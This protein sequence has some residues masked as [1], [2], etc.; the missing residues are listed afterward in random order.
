MSQLA[1]IVNLPGLV[2]YWPCDEATGTTVTDVT[3]SPANGAVSGSGGVLGAWNSPGGIGAVGL[4]PATSTLAST[5]GL[6]VNHTSSTPKLDVGDNFSVGM[7]F[8][9]RAAVT[10]SLWALGP[11][12]SAV[13]SELLIDSDFE[14]ATLTSWYVP[15]GTVTLDST[16]SYSG[17]KSAKIAVDASASN[18]ALYQTLYGGGA[19]DQ[20]EYTVTFWYKNDSNTTG[21]LTFRVAYTDGLGASQTITSVL[22]PYSATWTQ[23]TLTFDLTEPANDLTIAFGRLITAGGGVAYNMWV[24]AVSVKCAPVNPTSL[25]LSLDDSG[26]VNFTIGVTTV[27]SSSSPINDYLNWHY[28]VL[29]K[30]GSTTNLYIDGADVTVA[31]TNATFSTAGYHH[32]W[33]SGGIGLQPVVAGHM[34]LV[35]RAITASEQKM[36]FNSANM[37]PDK[38]TPRTLKNLRMGFGGFSTSYFAVPSYY[39]PPETISSAVRAAHATRMREMFTWDDAEPTQGT[40]DWSRNDG[41]VAAHIAN[42]VNIWAGFIISSPSWANS[43]SNKHV[44]PGSAYKGITVAAANNNATNGGKGANAYTIW[45]DLYIN[46]IVACV[47]RYKDRVFQWE[48]GNENNMSGASG[49]GASAP[50]FADFYNAARSAILAELGGA[51]YEHTV[52]LGPM[53][54][55]F[56]ETG[57]FLTPPGTNDTYSYVG[58]EFIRAL[59]DNGLGEIDRIGINPYLSNNADPT[60]YAVNGR[61]LS[62]VHQLRDTLME[63]GLSPTLQICEMGWYTEDTTVAAASDGVILPQSSITLV[64]ATRLASGT[65]GTVFIQSSSGR[66]YQQVTYTGKSGNTLTGCTGGVGSIAAGGLVSSGYSEPVS[67]TQAATYLGKTLTI[68]RDSFSAFCDTFSYWT[69]SGTAAGVGDLPAWT[70]LAMQNP[71]PIVGAFSDFAA[72]YDPKV[73]RPVLTP[74]VGAPTSTA[75]PSLGKINVYNCT[76]GPVSVSLPALA[77]IDQGSRL[78]VTKSDATANQLTLSCAGGDT[79]LDGTQSL[80]IP[81]RMQSEIQVAS[82]GGVKYWTPVTSFTPIDSLDSRYAAYT[83]VLSNELA[84]GESTMPRLLAGGTPATGNGNLR[85]C[86]F[87]A[88]KTETITS[89]RLTANVAQIGATLLRIGIYSEDGSGNLTLVASTASDTSLLVSAGTA[90]TKALSSSWSKVRG[91]RY[92]AGVLLVGTSQAP[93]MYGQINGGLDGYQLPRLSQMVTGLSDLP[94]TVAVGSLTKQDHMP[95]IAFVP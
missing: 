44:V 13:G 85:L 79:F 21:Q 62:G 3:A 32:Y 70:D 74:L 69:T 95:Y 92:A 35:N 48:I 37:L 82:V 65:S 88:R 26:N 9:R 54:N 31:G 75:S 12:Y 56:S 59:L 50:L 20:G 40:F 93:Y 53:C 23:Y 17:S 72:L 19:A 8:R 89:V 39:S 90:Y 52:T 46:Y 25:S 58:D 76:T 6:T 71:K 47:H 61:N 63:Y 28:L 36:I 7:F 42:G 45:R 81:V 78:M 38:A 10:G 5:A 67:A 16:T 94:S 57:T 24:D 60:V 33:F 30:S 84:S 43:D 15:V 66:P 11:H 2:A 64:D 14:D 68:V 51:A 77:S 91:T 83:D 18:V 73:A 34:F 29:T 41:V 87:T 1:A 4:R 22:P 27:A 49:P 55:Y 86:Y 80:T